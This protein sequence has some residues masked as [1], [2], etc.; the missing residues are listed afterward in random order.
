MATL[1]RVTT[2]VNSMQK[3]G[4]MDAPFTFKTNSGTIILT[5]RQLLQHATANDSIWKQVQAY[6]P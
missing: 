2:W 1:D 5:P 6:I 3:I 4:Q